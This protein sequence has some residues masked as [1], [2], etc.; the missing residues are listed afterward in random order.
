MGS[1]VKARNARQTRR[2]AK[3]PYPPK[4]IVAVCP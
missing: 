1:D 3:A 2:S 4:A